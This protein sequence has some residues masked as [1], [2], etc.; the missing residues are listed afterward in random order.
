MHENTASQRKGN[1]SF[2]QIILFS[3]VQM[4]CCW[5][6][7]AAITHLMKIC[8]GYDMMLQFMNSFW[9]GI[10]L[11][12]IWTACAFLS[13]YIISA[14]GNMFGDNSA[15]NEETDEVCDA[16]YESY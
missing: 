5:S 4:V 12:A 13:Y 14:A 6:I 11:F 7:F 3:P 15:Y 8:A 2:W 9:C 10:V 1:L 16:E